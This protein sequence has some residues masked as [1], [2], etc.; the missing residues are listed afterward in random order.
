MPQ[1]YIGG[2]V[3]KSTIKTLFK[4]IKKLE[5]ET[6]IIINLDDKISERFNKNRR[7]TLYNELS[8]ALEALKFNAS[9]KVTSELFIYATPL[10]ARVIL[11]SNQ[12][13]RFSFLTLEEILVFIQ[14][15]QTRIEKY[16]NNTNLL[17]L[18]S[19]F[20]HRTGILLNKILSGDLDEYLHYS[21][22]EILYEILVEDSELIK[23]IGIDPTEDS[24]SLRISEIIVRNQSNLRK[25]FGLKK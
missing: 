6:D 3:M 24:T 18:Y 13:Y 9:K 4:E 5:K 1:Q 25:M 17:T 22:S 2:K 10:E 11:N 19:E 12:F 23:K 8:V 20:T 7:E 15:D 14:F 16:L 21:A